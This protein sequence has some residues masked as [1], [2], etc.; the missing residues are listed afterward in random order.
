MLTRQVDFFRRLNFGH[1][2]C[3]PL[4]LL[5]ILAH[6]PNWDGGPPK[7][8]KGEHSKISSKFIT[9]VSITLGLMAITLGN[10]TRRRTAR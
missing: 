5:H 4:K 6:A 10:F 8:F 2:G 3:W 9:K 7:N 1:S